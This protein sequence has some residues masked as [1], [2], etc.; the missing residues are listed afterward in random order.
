MS[1]LP[2]TSAFNDGYI[3][4]MYES[5]L[6]DPA[7]VDESW[8]QFFRIAAELGGGTAQGYDPAML[9][10][11]AAAAALVSAIQ[12]FGHLAVQLDPL[13]TPPPGAAELKPEYHGITQ[14]D[15]ERLP[16]SAISAWTSGTAADVIQHLRERYCGTLAFDIEHVSEEAGY[17][18]RPAFPS[19]SIGPKTTA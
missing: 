12:H 10:K 8:R 2:I 15:L 1:N 11:A 3:A 19:Q 18:D 4:E 14:A 6:R 7:S 9:R 17:E 13:G 16:A 5:F